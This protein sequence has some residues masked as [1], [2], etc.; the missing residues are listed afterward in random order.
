MKL[1][2]SYNLCIKKKKTTTTTTTKQNKKETKKVHKKVINSVKLQNRMDTISMNSRN[3]K[4]SDLQ[5][6]LL[7]LT[8]KI[9]PT[10]SDKYVA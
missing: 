8:A 2:K 3:S 1:V 6:L 4:I 5:R 10:R 7:N 9:N